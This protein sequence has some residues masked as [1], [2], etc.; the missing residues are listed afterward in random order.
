MTPD[1]WFLR[2]DERG[3]RRTDIDRR[4]GDGR[5]YTEGNAVDVLVDGATYF[6]CLL[7]S[8]RRLEPGDRLMFTDWRGD[9]DER[10]DGPGTEIGRVLASLAGRGVDVRAL[11]WRSHSD[12]AHFS[13]KE[14]RDFGECV[15][16]AGGEVLLDERV[17]RAGS[18][19][20]KLVVMQCEAGDREVAFVGGIDLSH[21][22]HDD[23]THL[24][25]EQPVELDPRY[26]PRPPWHDAQ[27]QV[28]G[29]ALADLAH[30]FRERWDDP[31]PLDHRV[32]WRV[33][34][35]RIARV[36]RH[37]RPLPER[38][39][40]RTA[41]GNHA[42]QVLRTYPAKRPS[43]P[44]APDGE[45]SV[46][47]AY[48]KALR[49]ARALVYVEDQYL[50]SADAA[51][52]LAA[53]L[54][55]SPGLRVVVVVPRYPDR[56]GRFSGPPYRI[57]QQR[58]LRELTAAGPDRVSVYDLE[59]ES[60]WPIYVH[61]KVCIVDDVWLVVGSDN[62]NR[63]SWTN[64]SEVSC[65][66]VDDMRD[67]RE[68]RDP[69]GLGDGARRLARETRL[70]LWHEHSGIDVADLVDPV[71][72]FEALARA[73]AALEDW[74]AGGRRGPRPS[75]RLRPHRPEPVKGLAAVWARL[76]YGV[77][78]DPDGRPR[79]LRRAGRL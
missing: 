77:L 74:H 35:R 64:D 4:R 13:E 40:A 57:G 42:V 66:V 30:T 20:Q 34:L 3:N 71:A 61:A 75:G 24:G 73:A 28:R 48:L 11:V 50:W 69:G 14:N 36:P 23:E 76:V 72:G 26:G 19:H 59:A 8:L 54:R 46:A 38:E 25:D 56:D 51:R 45:R 16:E 63:R 67:E 7:E 1:D 27:L 58:A 2:P 9:A 43:F 37:P 39:S 41:R 31:T 47:R 22:R 70:R 21:G 52:A 18:H 10:L 15:N 49:R 5:A 65:A 55:R 62:L 32:P 44:F 53:A 78:V 60:G 33:V 17:R 68:P 79:S 6:R 29:P 12:R